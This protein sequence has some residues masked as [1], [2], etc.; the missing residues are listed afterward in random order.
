MLTITWGAEYFDDCDCDDD[1][2]DHDD[3]D[4]DGDDDDDKKSYTKQVLIPSA[5]DGDDDEIFFQPCHFHR[6]P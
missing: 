6:I 3:D 4:D 1:D 2:G 5:S